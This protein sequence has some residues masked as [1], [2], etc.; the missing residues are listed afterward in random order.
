VE[1]MQL[2][3]ID[4]LISQR[5]ITGYESKDP[6]VFPS[7]AVAYKGVDYIEK[8]LGDNDSDNNSIFTPDQFYEYFKN[9]EL[10]ETVNGTH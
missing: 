3:T 7:V 10:L 8:Y 6:G 9:L 2:H 4:S 1:D 5:Y